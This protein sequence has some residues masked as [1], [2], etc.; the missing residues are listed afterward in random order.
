MEDATLTSK[1]QLT[2]PRSVRDA[3]GVQAGDRIRFLPT[4]NGFR[5][6]A[7]KGDISK[8]R[9]MFKGRRTKPLSIDEMNRAIS[10]MGNPEGR[11]R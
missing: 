9:G 10:A 2:L 7:L 11:S 8:L 4:R 5:V 6:I 1:S 3:L